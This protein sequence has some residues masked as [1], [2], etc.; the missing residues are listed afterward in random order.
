MHNDLDAWAIV[1]TAGGALIGEIDH[2]GSRT[3]LKEGPLVLQNFYE[4]TASIG[5][6]PGGGGFHKT[7]MALPFM[8][9]ELGAPI[10]VKPVGIQ[11]LA[12]MKDSDKQRYKK[13]IDIAQQH[14]EKTRASDAGIQLARLQKE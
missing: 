9:T 12:D 14:S 7:L 3:H 13:L 8:G 10:T 1:L 2:P 4:L 6:L 11:Y 5:V